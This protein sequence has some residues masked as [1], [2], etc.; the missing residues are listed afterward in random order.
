MG[1]RQV[2]ALLHFMYC[3]E[4]VVEEDHLVD[5]LNAASSLSVTGLSHVT[6]ALVSSQVG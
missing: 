4:V 2:V 5:L 3:G 6:S 1:W